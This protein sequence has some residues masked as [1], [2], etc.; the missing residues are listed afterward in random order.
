MSG[1]LSVSVF[2]CG[3][4]PIPG[5]P[6]WDPN[7]Q[8]TWPASTS[9]L[10]SG[11]RDAILV[12]AL[13]TTAEGNELAGWVSRSGKNPSLVFITHG[14]GDHFFGAGPTLAAFPDAKLV[15]SAHEVV[16][17]ASGQVTEEGL[18]I[19]RVW[20]GGQFDEQAAVP[21]ALPSGEV[22]IEGHPVHLMS[23]GVGDGV[24]GTILHAPEIA[25]VCSGDIVYNNIHM[26]LWNST[27]ESRAEWIAS[28]G[29]VAA[30]E[31]KTIITG[32][33]DPAAPDDEAQRLMD[34]S[35][36]YIED[37]DRAVARSGSGQEVIDIMMEKYSR[38]G[39]PFTLFAAA[40]SQFGA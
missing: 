13:M 30:L 32:H 39:N 35:R 38:Y 6:G 9:T 17:E 8:A 28:I 16:D 19:W 40:H 21:T 26:W 15:A 34:Q 22:E 12:D 18:A 5:G 24:L 4:K 11:D 3:Y 20:F 23:M 33:K 2:N 36:H 29:A 10:I 37:F 25:T 7:K 31:P 14:H 27:R 1:S